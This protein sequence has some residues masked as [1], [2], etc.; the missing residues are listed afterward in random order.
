MTTDTAYPCQ[1]AHRLVFIGG[2]NM[3]EAIF[4]GLVR[5][6]YPADHIIVTAPRQERLNNLQLKFPGLLLTSDNRA[7][8]TGKA[9]NCAPA[10]I[11]ILCVKP[12]ILA[13]VVAEI[14]PIVSK[15]M[16][17]LS[18]AAG[19]STSSITQWFGCDIPVIRCM[20]N[21]PT[22]VGEGVTGLF[23]TQHVTEKQKI[24]TEKIL[25]NVSPIVCWVEN[26]DQIDTIGG[27][28]GSGPAYFFLFM[29]SM[30]RKAVEMGL[31]QNTAR[32]LCA[33]TCLGA[34]EM[35]LKTTDPLGTLRRN[36]TS[37]NG[38]TQA[39]LETMERFGLPGIIAE[40]IDAANLRRAEL[41]KEL[42]E[43]A[44]KSPN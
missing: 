10:D 41:A 30:I 21:T 32:E 15:N 11:V 26:E 39:G 12:Q 43:K 20:P 42:K 16:L 29:D 4:G 17:V 5:Q 19:I 8:I 24:L 14:K 34:A 31:P 44:L 3:A 38:T 36:V 18:V 13:S 27:L 37:P 22:F 28:S 2:G 7:A 40:A 35:V 1:T 25:K 6:D 23:A 9:F 33:Q